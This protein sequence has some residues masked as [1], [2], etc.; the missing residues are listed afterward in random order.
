MELN[1]L[2]KSNN[3]VLGWWTFLI[4]ISIFNIL[5]IS[6]YAF[7]HT[8]NTKQL[9]LFGFAF[10]F[11]IVCAIR[12]FY[13]TKYTEK[14]CFL[15][16]KY[17]TPFVIRILAT[18][19]EIVYILL[20]VYVFIY[21]INIIKNITRIN[22]NYL[23]KYIYIV[24]PIIVLAEVFSWLGSI[25][26]Y[27]LW[28]VSEEILWLITSIMLIVISIFILNNIK[29][30]K[31]TKIKSIYYLLSGIVPLA[32]IFAT[33]LIVVD[34]PMYVKRWIKGEQLEA[35]PLQQIFNEF[36]NKH[37]KNFDNNIKD[38]RQCRKVDK[39]LNTWK[40]EMPWLTGYFTIGVWSTFVLTIW[41]KHHS[42]S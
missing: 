3:V 41:F 14:T 36:K 20:F 35:K 17:Y 33:F 26:E 13:P 22:L 10:I 28:N 6:I 16:T 15:K 27:Q 29:N 11:S 32:T 19:A 21:I 9:I 31:S 34:I 39:S 5:F 7:T 30:I 4:I 42:D 23:K 24:I 8:L 40:E 12:A 25:T 38:F 2:M 1:A 37:R 18:I